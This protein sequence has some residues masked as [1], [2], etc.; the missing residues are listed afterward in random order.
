MTKFE[1][2]GVVLQQEAA[3]PED[4]LARMRY[5]C[6]CCCA[7]GLRIPCDQCSIKAAHALTLGAFEALRISV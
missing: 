5:S 3:S 7:R 2:I 1:S 6:H 4:S